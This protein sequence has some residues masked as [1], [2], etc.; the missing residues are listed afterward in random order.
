MRTAF[1]IIIFIL[2][3][4]MLWPSIVKRNNDYNKYVCAVN[5]MMP[6]YKTK[7]PISEQ[8]K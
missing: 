2:T 7:L 4:I 6:D 5:G 1:F 8:L 3:I